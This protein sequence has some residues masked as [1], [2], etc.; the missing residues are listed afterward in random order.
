[1]EGSVCETLEPFVVG[2][3]CVSSSP[4]LCIRWAARRRVLGEDVLRGFTD[5]VTQPTDE[6]ETDCE[7]RVVVI[8][9]G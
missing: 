8:L 2:R 1:M 4:L 5:V 9:A 6:P 7:A 3:V